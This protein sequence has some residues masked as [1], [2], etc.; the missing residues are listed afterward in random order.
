MTEQLIDPMTGEDMQTGEADGSAQ[1][2]AAPLSA[3]DATNV[4]PEDGAEPVATVETVLQKKQ[5]SCAALP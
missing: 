4:A 3:D 5:T 1:T 2:D